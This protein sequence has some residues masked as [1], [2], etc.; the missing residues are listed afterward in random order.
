MG[1]VVKCN[2]CGATYD[3][4]ESIELTKKWIADGYAPCPNI[5]CS[6]EMEVK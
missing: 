5:G 6:G 3:D 2:G 4:P 1:E